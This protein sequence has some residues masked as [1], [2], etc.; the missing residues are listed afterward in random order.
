MCDKNGNGMTQPGRPDWA[1]FDVD[2]RE[3]YAVP[4]GPS[5]R[6]RALIIKSQVET[7][8]HAAKQHGAKVVATTC[9]NPSCIPMGGKFPKGSLWVSQEPEV[10]EWKSQLN[11]SQLILIEKRTCGSVEANIAMRSW[12]VFKRNPHASNVIRSMDVSNW[13]IFGHS[14]DACVASTAREI[15]QLGFSVTII[16]D[17]VVARNGTVESAAGTLNTLSEQGA[18]LLTVEQ[19]LSELPPLKPHDQT[20]SN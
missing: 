17:A 12:E 2:T 1:L 6:E 15:M 14:A 19:F 10:F 5:F 7:L 4:A 9:S 8:L 20:I 3:R 18:K 11:D 16:R 13:V